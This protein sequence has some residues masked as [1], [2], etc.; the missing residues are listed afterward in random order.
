MRLPRNFSLLGLAVM[1]ALVVVAC[2]NDE[3]GAAKS[4][5]GTDLELID[6]GSLTT[7]TDAPYQPFEFE[8]EDGEFTGFDMELLRAIAGNLGIE[9]EVTVQP[10]DGIWLAPD[11]GTCD[12]VASAM[13][14]TEERQEAAV[15]SDPYFEADQ[16]LL[17]P[18]DET[19]E[20]SDLDALAGKTIGVQTGTTGAE[21][22]EENKP[23][24][25]TVKEFDEAAG[26]FLA[27][28]SGD[29]AAILQDFPVNA[30]RATQDDKFAVTAKFPT[31]EQYGFAA[32]KDNT[33]LIDAVNKEL[34]NLRD[35]GT[36]DEIFKEWFG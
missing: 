32:S 14:I 35:D 12:I 24:G 6:A 34:E 28:E 4:T 10:F 33:E 15:F 23:E 13:T 11:A 16:S 8:G 31:G 26:M 22:A 30:Y 9:L 19:D 27:L 18:A 1:I 20:L 29:I 17:V 7:C 36:Y 25:A 3:N 21:Y 2:G 5:A